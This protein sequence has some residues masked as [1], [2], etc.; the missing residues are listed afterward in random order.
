MG[1]DETNTN[2]ALSHLEKD[3]IGK[4]LILNLCLCHKL[5]L[6]IHAAFEKNFKLNE[7]A[8]V[9]LSSTY[10]L[11]RCANIKWQLFKHHAITVGQQ[12]RRFKRPSGTLWVAHQVDALDTFF[13]NL[14]TLLGYLHNQIANPYNAT[15]HK[16]QQRL[17]GILSNCS[18]LVVLIFNV[19]KSDILRLIRPTSLFLESVSVSFA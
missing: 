13:R 17:E 18:N 10:Y 19:I 2:K 5:E 12:H 16:E 15:M 7:D 8:E 3:E 1:S 4:H 11:F 6:A 14:Y 9:L